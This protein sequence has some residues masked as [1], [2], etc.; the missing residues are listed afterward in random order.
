MGFN[1]FGRSILIFIHLYSKEIVYII[2]AYSYQN[3]D[4]FEETSCKE[5]GIKNTPIELRELS[6]ITFAFFGIF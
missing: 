1:Q 6:Q 5:T 3:T 4:R 2:N